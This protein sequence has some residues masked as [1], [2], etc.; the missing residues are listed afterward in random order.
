MNAKA[1]QHTISTVPV[2][3]P[4][5]QP[6]ASGGFPWGKIL[7][8]LLIAALGYGVYMRLQGQPA[9]GPGFGM[10]AGAVPVDVITVEEK[11]ARLW[12]QFSARLT[13]VEQ[14]EIRPQVGGRITKVNFVEG[15]WVQKGQPLLVID[16]RPYQAQ[17]SR[18]EAAVTAAETRLRLANL[19]FTRARTLVAK[20]AIAQRLF[21]ER[22]N[23][24]KVAESDLQ[25]ARGTLLQATVDL[26]HAYVEAPITGRAGRPELTVGNVVETG[27][28]Q[29]PILTTIVDSRKLYAEFNVDE[30]TYVNLLSDS[31]PGKDR[32]PVKMTLGENQPGKDAKVYE[33]V[34][35]AF[36]NS[37]NTTTGTIRARAVFDNKDG[38][39]VPGLFATVQ[40]GTAKERNVLT[41]PETALNTDQTK[42]YVFVVDATNKATY[43][44]VTLGQAV[45]GGRV[46]N[47]GLEVG[48]KVV[49]GGLQRIRPGAEVQPLTPFDKSGL[50]EPAAQP[51]GEDTAPAKAEEAPAIKQ[52][53]KPEPKAA[54]KAE[55]TAAPEAKKEAPKTAAP[56]AATK[57]EPK[58]PAKAKAE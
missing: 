39:L 40:I 48:D 16:P 4:N 52:E 47:T 21:D 30:D 24:V 26:D 51:T 28:G 2:Y 12:T 22:E 37:F 6:Q 44:E 18:G 38:D 33:G 1:A 31:K 49:V 14:A 8:L 42:K 11:N 20:Q 34:L 45:E 53:V 57:A 29:A 25:A 35:T 15:S 23:N 58:T 5:Q 54:P 50:V 41:V 55:K 17:V 13:A 43:R 7:L 27:G 3:K 56:K 9:Q 32:I 19:E 10:G 36:D 46:V